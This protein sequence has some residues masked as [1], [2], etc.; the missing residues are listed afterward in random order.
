MEKDELVMM[1]ETHAG[2]LY[3][4]EKVDDICGT[5][6]EHGDRLRTVEHDQTVLKTQVSTIAVVAGVVVSAISNVALFIGQKV[7][8]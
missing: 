3:L 5:V 2:V 6:Q 1:A 4:K 8:K 7:M